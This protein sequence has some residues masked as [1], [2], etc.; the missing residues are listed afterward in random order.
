[1]LPRVLRFWLT[2]AAMLC[3]AGPGHAAQL[4]LFLGP[5]LPPAPRSLPGCLPPTDALERAVW[6]V[7]T[8]GGRPDL[9]CGNAFAGY[10]RT[11]RS[12]EV[13]LDAFE[14]IAAQV[15]NA[16]SEVLLSSM[17]W[18]AGPGHPG[19]TFALAVANLYGRVRANPAAYPHGMAVRVLMGGFPDLTHP[20]G[21]SQPLAL[22][23]DLW[24][25]GVPLDDPAVGW[26]LSLLNY[27]Y[28][29]HSHIKMHV[30][31]GRT[32][33]VGGFNFTDWH[34][35]SPQAGGVEPGGHDLQDLGL[36]MTGPVAQEGVAAFDDLW[37]HSDELRC[38]PGV[39]AAQLEAR[40]RMGPPGPVT[41]PPAA[42]EALASG[43]A[44]AFLL[45]RRSGVDQADRAH[46]ALLGAA[47]GSIDVMHADFSPSLNCWYAYLQPGSCG[48]ETWPV[49][50]RAVLSALERGVHVRVLTVNYGVGAGPNRSGIALMRREAR[51]RGLD[52]LFEGRYVTRAMHTKALTVDRR[53][54]VV[55]SMN[56]HF[57]SWGPLGLAEAALATG[58]PAAVGEQQASFEQ[59]WQGASVPVAPERWLQNVPRD[60]AGP[61][62]PAGSGDGH[63]RG[64]PQPLN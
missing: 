33:A 64:L 11:P 36:Q 34:L 19:W 23:G 38:P 54:V 46:L 29:P 35:P 12:P 62:D 8:Q 15:A 1:V 37:R 9:S 18:H 28:L 27:R 60:L 51:R 41:H 52:A 24:R 58:D 31:D 5:Q 30:I 42:Q 59:E 53:M 2:L 22:A 45:Y 10:L 14:A 13:R 25:L 3:A 17:E 4:P 44:R 39:S 32:V 43:E 63:G 57:S 6:E 48:V 47:R 49:Y 50:L 55:G 16:R 61:P 20:D 26:H 56:L 21:R 7:V 40:C